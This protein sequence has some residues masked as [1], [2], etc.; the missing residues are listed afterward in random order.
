MT[1][2]WQLL[3]NQ[4]VS[5]SL[6]ELIAVILAISYLLLA[7]K[8]RIE[9]WPAAFLSSLVYL[10]VF[11]DVQLYME[12]LLQIYYAGMAVYGWQQWQRDGQDQPLPIKTWRLRQHLINLGLIVTATYVIGSVLIQTDARLPYLDAFTTV[13]S[14][15]ATYMVTQ[16][17]L[18][19]WLYWLIIDIVS[20]YLYIDRALYFTALLFCIYIIIIGFGWRQW[21]VLWRA[22]ATNDAASEAQAQ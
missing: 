13:S 14:I 4:A 18:E 16:K 10:Y 19:N 12:S 7:V 6:I 15:F 17:V 1:N 9:C 2:T 11:F 5:S 20:I 21:F 8:Q 22:Q 3:L